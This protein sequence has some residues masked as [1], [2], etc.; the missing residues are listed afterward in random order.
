[1]V[2][3]L[4]CN[5]CSLLVRIYLCLYLTS[6]GA[7]GVGRK[8]FPVLW[9]INSWACVFLCLINWSLGQHNTLDLVTSPLPSHTCRVSTI[10]YTPDVLL[11]PFIDTLFMP[12]EHGK[13]CLLLY[14]APELVLPYQKMPCNLHIIEVLISKVQLDTS[15]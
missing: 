2:H 10:P 7:Q 8:R 6:R 12:R 5:V 3:I 4:N 15:C 11:F 13:S 14:S 9:E 1:M